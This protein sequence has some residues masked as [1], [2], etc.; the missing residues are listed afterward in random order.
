[1]T[2][3]P[4]TRLQIP[5]EVVFR[6]LGGESVLLDLRAGTYFGLNESG[7]RI[8]QLI[9]QHGTVDAVCDEMAQEFEVDRSALVRDVN[10]LVDRLIAR[11]L[12]QRVDE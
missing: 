8:W 5:S 2:R 3:R 7:T 4:G 12:L 9:E 10:A 6:E 11:G 1:M